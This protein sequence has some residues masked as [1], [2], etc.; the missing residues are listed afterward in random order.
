MTL[1][2]LWKYVQPNWRKIFWFVTVKVKLD[3]PYC[4]DLNVNAQL[5]MEYLFRNRNENYTHA[6]SKLLGFNQRSKCLVMSVMLS[7]N[8]KGAKY[9]PLS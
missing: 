4:L 5:F 7:L 8:K 2:W 6:I 3:Q 9:Q 1:L